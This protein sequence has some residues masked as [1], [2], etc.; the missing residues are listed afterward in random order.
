MGNNSN[1]NINNIDNNNDG[2]S[3]TNDNS[4]SDSDNNSSG[5]DGGGGGGANI[6]N[7]DKGDNKCLFLFLKKIYKR[8]GEQNLSI[9]LFK[10]IKIFSYTF[11]KLLFILL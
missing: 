6:S 9:F 4:N 11:R 8:L 7:N 2:N 1:N 3:N 10:K 5:S